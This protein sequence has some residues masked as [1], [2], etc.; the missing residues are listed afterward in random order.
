MISLKGQKI[1][2]DF[3]RIL[4][5]KGG[6]YALWEAGGRILVILSPMGCSCFNRS[7]V[8]GYAL[9]SADTCGAT[10]N[11]LLPWKSLIL[12]QPV[13]I[14]ENFF[15]ELYENFARPSPMEADCIIKKKRPELLQTVARCYYQGL[16]LLAKIYHK[17]EDISA[18]DSLFG[19]TTISLTHGDLATLGSTRL[20]F[21]AAD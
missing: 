2:D 21:V 12:S 5:P 16:F 20:V 14:P 6:V 15:R 9:L 7:H 17:G 11:N 1:L 18:G 19:S 10:A 3:P 13:R 4:M 8:D